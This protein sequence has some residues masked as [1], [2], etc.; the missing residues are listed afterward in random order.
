ME[1]KALSMNELKNAFYSLKSNKNPSHD[2]VSYNVIK[3]C[4]DS[5]R[6]LLKYLFNLSIEKGVV[7]D[8][9]KIARVTP[10]YKGEDN[11]DVSNY[12]PIFILPCFSKILERIMYNRLYKYSIENN[13]LL[14]NFVSKTVIQLTML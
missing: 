9:L 13:I 5:L 6:E 3:K 1:T 11:S 12:R 10:I 8:D 2:N 7:P 14:H 4:F